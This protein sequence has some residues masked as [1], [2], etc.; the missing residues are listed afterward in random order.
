MERHL[1]RDRH[2]MYG[3]LFWKRATVCDVCT[4]RI[5][6]VTDFRD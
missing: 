2:R 3:A 1:L 5:V 4:G 6:C